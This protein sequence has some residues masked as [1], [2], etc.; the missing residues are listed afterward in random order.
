MDKKA[1]PEKVEEF[2]NKVK[3]KK[4][5][6]SLWKTGDNYFI[7][8]EL[9]ESANLGWCMYGGEYSKD[10]NILA[11]KRIVVNEAFVTNSRRCYWEWYEEP[12]SMVGKKYTV[13]VDCP[14]CSPLKR[15]EIV[16]ILE[17]LSNGSFEVSGGWHLH[18]KFLDL[19]DV[20]EIHSSK[21]LACQCDLQT[22]IM[23]SGCQ[24]GRS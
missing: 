21:R 14:A 17:V 8:E 7:P 9:I 12:R 16:E 20:T 23:V 2:F 10:G 13:N 22:V 1:I 18:P 5:K 19:I 6:R 24:C 3:G 4:I 15:G 11:K